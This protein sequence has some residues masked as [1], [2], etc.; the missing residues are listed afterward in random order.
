MVALFESLGVSTQASSMSFS[1]SQR[2]TRTGGVGDSGEEVKLEWSSEAPFCGPGNWRNPAFLNMLREVVRFGKEAPLLLPERRAAATAGK[3]AG[4]KQKTDP[5]APAAPPSTGGRA[6]PRPTS[7]ADDATVSLGDYLTAHGYSQAFRQ[8]YVAPMIAAVWSC[9]TAEALAMP[10]APLI[11]FWVNHHLL[12]LSGRPQWRTVRGGSRVYVEACRRHVNVV[13]TGARVVRVERVGEREGSTGSVG[14]ESTDG[15]TTAERA[16]IPSGA[17]EASSPKPRRSPRL[18]GKEKRAG[19]L[20][21]CVAE[22]S[23]KVFS[24]AR[25]SSEGRGRVAIYLADG[26]VQ[27]FDDVVVAVHSDVALSLLGGS[28]GLAAVPTA[29]PSPPSSAS[30]GNSGAT[31]PSDAPWADRSIEGKAELDCLRAIPYASNDVWLH[32]DASLMPKAK[33]AWACWNFLGEMDLSVLSSGGSA[34][35]N[36]APPCVT[37]WANLLQGLPASAPDVFVTLN[38][39][40]GREP[41]PETVRRRLRMD[42]PLCMARAG[43]EARRQLPG[44]QGRGG[45]WFAG[46]WTGAG[47]HEDGLRSAV[48]V[49]CGADAA[50]GLGDGVSSVGSVGGAVA[51][52]TT[53]G[54]PNMGGRLP[55]E[56]VAT[57]PRMGLRVACL[58][59]L[60]DRFLALAVTRGRLTI[61][62]PDGSERSYGRAGYVGGAPLP[63]DDLA[64]A[65]GPIQERWRNPPAPECTLRVIRALPFIWKCVSRH[66]TGLGEAWMAGDVVCGNPGALMACLVLNADRAEGEAR[67]ALGLLNTLGDRILQ[68]AHA[69]RHN[70]IVNAKKN[71]EEHYD[72]GNAMYTTFLDETM[73]YSCGLHAPGR[74]LTE[75]QERKM[76]ALLDAAAVGPGMRVLEVGCGW[77]ALA[78]RAGRRVGKK[79][80]VVGLTLSKEQLAE[81]NSRVAAAGL[82]DVVELLLCDYRNFPGAGTYDA[83]VSCEMIEA[84]GHAYLPSFHRCVAD[85]L[86]E[87][88]MAAIQAI[89]MPDARYE[90]YRRGSDFIREHIFPGGHLPSVGA[91]RGACRQSGARLRLEGAT[92]IGPN[93]A[94]TLREWRTA[95]ER[96]RADVIALG[97]SDIFWRKYQFYFAYCEAAFDARYISVLH[98]RWTK[99]SSLGDKGCGVG[100]AVPTERAWREQAPVDRAPARK[101]G[102]MVWGTASAG[103][104]AAVRRGGVAA[105]LAP[106]LLRVATATLA[107][108][109]VLSWQAPGLVDA[110]VEWTAR[111]R[112]AAGLLETAAALPPLE[113]VVGGLVALAVARAM[114]RVVRPLVAGG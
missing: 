58:A 24:E 84:V 46:A 78:I 36:A 1:L 71:I 5:K 9:P 50:L 68:A 72:A 7:N 37:Y 65:G 18:A 19:R 99:D 110:L 70:S 29:I 85:A 100:P 106:A 89:V 103:V 22:V 44:L 64:D 11:R 13:R 49:V 77:G 105:G 52:S 109:A 91:M 14:A 15:A 55:W 47:F 96:R 62:W 41:R 2:A 38:P 102:G 23:S 69:A 8:W 111:R 94:V 83:V 66:D 75:A 101:G 20:T 45:V 59:P 63:E 12:D 107:A 4:A 3:A 54:P 42:H 28:P 90:K 27:R 31:L 60:I 34:D 17:T 32:T 112:G 104:A 73:T 57:S 113:L 43:V 30:S 95:W 79:G 56:P 86:K 88:G 76:E 108:L 39:P 40:A 51:S 35:K 81:A 80:K 10:A 53:S 98:L 21:E 61:V 48:A 16:T 82:S 92:D 33:A 97:Y 6:G 67:G 26:S 87:G 114:A 74:S 93:Y 25:R